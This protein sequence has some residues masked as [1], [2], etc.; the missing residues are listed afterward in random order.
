[1]TGIL[2]AMSGSP[3]N[4]APNKPQA[5]PLGLSEQPS[6]AQGSPFRRASGAVPTSP[7]VQPT[8]QPAVPSMSQAVA[9]NLNSNSLLM[10]SAAAQ[11]QRM[12]ASRGLQNSTV[13]IEAA[14]R[15]MIDAA[16]PIAQVDVGNQHQLNLQRDQQQFSAQQ[17]A[18][19]REHQ[20]ATTRLNAELSH[21]N[22]IK[23]LE[24]Q[25]AANTV[26]KSIDFAMQIANNFDAQIA[27]ILNNTQMQAGDKAKAI[28]QL[29][30]SRDSE[31]AF[32]TEFM[33]KMPTSK[34]N[35]AAFPELGVPTVRI[36]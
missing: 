12:A 32:M 7:T 30:A 35:W 8:T 2:G 14:Q 25:V 11:G 4:N 18:L 9:D 20:I 13:G 33:Q 6:N 28:E 15:A 10:K 27:G 1:M 31:V 34:Q 36:G 3:S 16:M 19:D 17:A 22:A 29:K 5:K 21:N 26:G 24:K 23:E